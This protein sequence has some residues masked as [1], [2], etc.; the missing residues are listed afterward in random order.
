[1]KILI[2]SHNKKKI[3]E[4]HDILASVLG[5]HMPLTLLSMDDVGFT[6]DAEETGTTFAENAMIKAKDGARSGYITIADDSGL[7]VDALG[8]APGVYSARYAGED[9]N[10]ENNKA[11]LLKN[12]RNVATEKRTARFVCSIACVFPDGRTLTAE[13]CCEGRILEAESGS[14]GFGYDPLFYYPPLKKSFALLTADEKNAV[15]HR[16]KALRAF[17]GKFADVWEKY[18]ADK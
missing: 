13:E 9:K 18:Y 1:M 6:E 17:A 7:V 15:S 12:L 16:G 14:G 8:G 4:L 2:A 3:R 10:D 11:L 5:E